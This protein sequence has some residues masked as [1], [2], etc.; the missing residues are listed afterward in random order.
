[1]G[2]QKN[3]SILFKIHY[4]PHFQQLI[5]ST[6]FTSLIFLNY[7]VT[8]LALGLMWYKSIPRYKLYSLF[9]V[10]IPFFEAIICYSLITR[11]HGLTFCLH[12][13]FWYSR[14]TS[15]SLHT[16]FDTYNFNGYEFNQR[17]C[18]GQQCTV[19]FLSH[20]RALTFCL[21]LRE[22]ELSICHEQRCK[23]LGS[24]QILMS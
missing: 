8:Y 4:F 20:L 7:N 14:T 24:Q 15:V 19:G 3:Y 13:Q 17:M 9:W 16:L 6:L 18:C 2:F 22:L 12:H 21:Q 5:H 10:N 11:N 23:N 1:M